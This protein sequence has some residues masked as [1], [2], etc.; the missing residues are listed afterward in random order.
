VRILLFTV[1]AVKGKLFP[2]PVTLRQRA[3][4]ARCKDVS[5]KAR[6]TK[7]HRF[8]FCLFRL[9]L[10]RYRAHSC[11]DETEKSTLGFLM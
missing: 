11:G 8:G 9:W 3:A 10:F 5:F 4:P 1:M 2:V 6:R 7:A